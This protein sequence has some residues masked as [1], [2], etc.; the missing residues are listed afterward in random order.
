MEALLR[1]AAR[2]RAHLERNKSDKYNKKVSQKVESNVRRISEYYKRKGVLPE[3][4]KYVP[5]AIA[6]A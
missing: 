3:D 6:I 4:W 2:L 5:T 1:K